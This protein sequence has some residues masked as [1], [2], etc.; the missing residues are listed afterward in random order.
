MKKYTLIA[1]IMVVVALLA[2]VFVYFNQSKKKPKSGEV[3]T[4]EVPNLNPVSKTNPFTN[5][6]TNPFE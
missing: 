6:K 5:I 4:A 1:S 2:G 3:P